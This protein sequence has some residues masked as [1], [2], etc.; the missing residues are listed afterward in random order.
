MNWTEM[1]MIRGMFE[2]K[3]DERKKSDELRELE[4]VSLMI[5]NGRL[6]CFGRAERSPNLLS[7]DVVSNSSEMRWRPG[8]C[9]EPRWRTY[10]A[11]PDTLLHQGEG[12]KRKKEAR[13]RGRG[14]GKG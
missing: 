1:R 11:S 14:I 3:L 9:A 6:S 10:S 2:V 12:R 4:P 5:K 7:P 13:R 8:L